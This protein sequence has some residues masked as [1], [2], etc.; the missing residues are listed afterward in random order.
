MRAYYDGAVCEDTTLRGALYEFPGVRDDVDAAQL[1]ED[2][3]T[4]A[5]MDRMAPTAAQVQAFERLRLSRMPKDQATWVQALRV[6]PV[7]FVGLPGEI[8]VEIGLE[9]KQ[10]SVC[11]DTHC[12]ELA[13]DWKAYIPTARACAEGSYETEIGTARRLVPETGAQMVEAALELIGRVW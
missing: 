2:K 6:G 1:T 12:V 8:F 9:I 3:R 13:N 10:R 11:P 4:V 5:G 7:V